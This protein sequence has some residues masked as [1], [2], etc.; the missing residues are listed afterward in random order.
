MRRPICTRCGNRPCQSKGR[1]PNNDTI[2]SN[3]CWKCRQPT[4]TASHEHRKNAIAKSK[5][6]Q[7]DWKCIMCGFVPEHPGQMDLDHIDGNRYNNESSNHQLLCANCHR[8]KTIRNGDNMKYYDYSREVPTHVARED[9]YC[10]SPGL[11]PS[12]EACPLQ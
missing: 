11:I 8:L 2:W 4:L 10:I 6:A 12:S 7:K 3:L 9:S 1:K 5:L